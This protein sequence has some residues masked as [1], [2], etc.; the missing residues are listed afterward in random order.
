M[1]FIRSILLSSSLHIVLAV[2]VLLLL[3]QAPKYP[4]KTKQEAHAVNVTF[5]P[6][7][8]TKAKDEIKG[9][10]MKKKINKPLHMSDDCKEYYG[11]IGVKMGLDGTITEVY[12]GYPGDLL[13]VL[14][15]D[16]LVQDNVK[17]IPGTEVTFMIRRNNKLLTF[18]TIRDKICYRKGIP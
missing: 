12:P 5:L 7:S 16:I 2:V 1:S 6:P 14:I 10:G 13:G 9:V 15:G 17:G 4:A 18:T 8:R 3:L 11:G